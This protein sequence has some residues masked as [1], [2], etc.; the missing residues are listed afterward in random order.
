MFGK[1]RKNSKSDRADRA[2]YKFLFHIPPKNNRFIA[3]DIETSGFKKGNYITEIGASEIVENEVTNIQKAFSII[4][5][6]AKDSQDYNKNKIKLIDLRMWIGNS[7]IFAHNANFDMQVINKAFNFYGIETIPKIN[8][9]CTMKIFLE[10][11]GAVNPSY[12][13]NTISLSKCCNFFGLKTF[14]QKYHNSKT[15]S[16]MKAKLVTSLYQEID[17]NPKLSMYNNYNHEG[18]LNLNYHIYR[19]IKK[20]N[21]KINSYHSQI[22]IPLSKYDLPPFLRSNNYKKINEDERSGKEGNI[23]N[24]KNGRAKGTQNDEIISK[25]I[26]Y[27]IFMPS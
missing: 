27:N 10:I 3:L 24:I 13:M 19:S 8:F 21:N 4:P 11:I 18:N 15:D 2:N 9:R 14:G 17:N 12:N 26:L 23:S 22:F 5:T 6:K 1:K 25:E 7:I 16:M 20:N